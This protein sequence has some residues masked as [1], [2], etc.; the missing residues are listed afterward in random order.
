VPEVGRALPAI[1]SSI[2]GQSPTYFTILIPFYYCATKI[3]RSIR[4]NSNGNL[5]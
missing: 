2:V 3:N 4:I 5:D 1:V